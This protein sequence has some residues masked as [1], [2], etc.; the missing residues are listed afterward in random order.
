MKHAT[1]C[2]S[3][4]ALLAAAMLALALPGPCALAGPL[5]YNSIEAPEG[6]EEPLQPETPRLRYQAIT[7]P[8]GGELQLEEL[9]GLRILAWQSS[10]PQVASV[11]RKGLVRALAGGRAVITAEAETGL[12]ARCTVWVGTPVKSI[13]LDMKK[14]RARV[15]Q[16]VRLTAT[17]QPE[18]A[19]NQTVL[20]TSSNPEVATVN[21][22]GVVYARAPGKAVITAKTQDRG[23]KVNFTLRV[24]PKPEGI[25]LNTSEMA[26]GKGARKRIR[27]SLTPANALPSEFVWR[28]NKPAVATVDEKGRVTGVSSGTAVITVRDAEGLVKARCTVTV[29]LQNRVFD[30]RI[31]VTSAYRRPERPDHNALDIVGL[32]SPR[33]RATVGG[34]VR[35]ARMFDK[36]A[37]GRTWEWG[38]FVW[39]EGEDGLN[40]IYAHMAEQPYVHEG[41]VVKA[42]TVL[43]IMGN[44]GYSFGVHT[45]YEI[46]KPNGSTVN[47]APYTGVPNRLG[48]YG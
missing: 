4:A 29:G 35:Y 38:Y 26:L 32:D 31:K 47:P 11:T 27:A 41:S 20:Y 28:S 34:R 8:E 5:C 30:G 2:R 7:L 6:A 14:A 44:T 46:R 16:R 22:K 43:G 45:H 3:L 9:N 1:L 48:V 12:K 37:G 39:I 19:V 13:K 36:S 15:G 40:H 17:I 18:D 24:H 23:R 42:G 33:I 10:K 21:D 25:Q